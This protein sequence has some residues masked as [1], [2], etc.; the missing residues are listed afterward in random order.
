MKK[1][2]ISIVV[3]CFNEVDNIIP[4]YKKLELVIRKEK[5]ID[6]EILFVNDGSSDGTLTKTRELASNHN[7]TKV[8]N[9]S[10]NFGKEIATTAGISYARGDAII[11]LDAD[12]QH[13]PELIPRFIKKW[14]NGAK[15]VVGVRKTNQKE[16]FIKRYG[17]KIFYLIINKLQSTKM[18]AGSTDFRLIDKAVRKEFLKLTEHN[19]ITRGIIDWIGFKKDYIEFHANERMS[20]SA[21]Y[22]IT[23]LL[24]LMI[25]SFVSLSIK[26]LYLAIWAGVIILPLSILLGLFSAVEMA[27]GD[28]LNLNITGGA[29]IGLTILFLVG[30]ILIS[31]GITALYLSHIHSETQNRP[32]F[33]IDKDLSSNLEEE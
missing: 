25:D 8:V 5:A 3:P 13:P 12:G 27:I 1:P 2:F 9:L 18:T 28:P 15:V 30:L 17:S 29:Y 11:M 22:S 31:Q 10:R 32:L 6:F 7:N 26:P 33:I 20:G 19:R 4:L 16:G 21:S 24:K 23:K 14:V